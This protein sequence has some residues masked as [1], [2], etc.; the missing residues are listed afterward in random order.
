MKYDFKN[1]EPKWQKILEEKGTFKAV[2]DFS[3]PKFY[4]LVE[5]PSI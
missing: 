5:F 3:R 1:I 2:D 4:G